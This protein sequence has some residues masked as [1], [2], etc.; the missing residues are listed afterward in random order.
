MILRL[1]FGDTEVRVNTT[2][3][4][5][6]LIASSHRR[7]QTISAAG[8]PGSAAGQMVTVEIAPPRCSPEYALREANR[9]IAGEVAAHHGW[10]ALQAVVVERDG[11]AVALVGAAGTGK[12]TVA[13]HLVARDWRLV[14]DDVAFVDDRRLTIVPHQG[15]MN[16]RSSA[17]PHLPPSFRETLERSRW[18]VDAHGELQFY[19]V[20]PANVFGAAA[21][22][23]EAVL[24]AI[25]V[26]DER[27]GLGGIETIDRDHVALFTL[28]GQPLALQPFADLRVGVIRK[29]IAQ[30]NAD[31]IERWYD[32][33]AGV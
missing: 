18:F 3:T 32:A 6:R 12:S 13:A 19:E 10:R 16:F 1:M 22:A 23:P 31:Q 27:V 29:G 21:W 9:V 20:D 15:L 28:D 11:R 2:S 8:A 5:S 25:V 17:I 24:D 30:T 14:S 26:I 33:R 7:L 4:L